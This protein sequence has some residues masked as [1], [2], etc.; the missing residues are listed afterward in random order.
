MIVLASKS[1]RRR[2]MMNRISSSFLTYAPEIDEKASYIFKSPNQIVID[3]AK[4]KGFASLNKYPNDIIIAADTI[5]VLKDQILG[6]P[7]DKNDAKRI[8]KLLSDKEHMVITAYV[9]LSKNKLMINEVTSYVQMNN[10]DDQFIEKYIES[11]SP[12]DK[13]GAYGIQDNSKFPI[14]RSYAGSFDNIK[15]F[16]VLEIKRDLELFINEK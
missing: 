12:L 2:E 13:A 11:G 10:L 1:P 16:P 8:L 4:R 5:V 14:V 6:K 15:G 7:K 9:I 3:I